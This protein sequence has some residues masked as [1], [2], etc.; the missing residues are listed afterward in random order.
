MSLFSKL[1][2]RSEE[3]SDA[4]PDADEYCP[5]AIAGSEAR[6]AHFARFGVADADIWFP[7]VNPAFQGGPEWPSRPGWQ[8]VVDGARTI[9]VS[10]GLSDPFADLSLPNVG[11]AVEVLAETGDDIPADMRANWLFHIVCQ[12]SHTVADHGQFRPL[13]DQYE[14]GTFEISSFPG[15]EAFE[16]ADG[17]VGVFLGM[18]APGRELSMDL[19]GGHVRIVTVKQLWPSELQHA[20]AGGA[21]AYRF[22]RAAFEEDGTHHISS[23]ARPPAI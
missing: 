13:I 20:M 21:D 3:P 19:P 8:R 18:A 22:L 1:F 17:R 4:A 14:V 16:T 11:N 7:L 5:G 9:V 10:T 2:G 6:H 23:L 12:T 15:L